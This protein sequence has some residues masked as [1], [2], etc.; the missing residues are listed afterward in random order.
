MAEQTVSERHDRS[1]TVIAASETKG[2]GRWAGIAVFSAVV[3]PIVLAYIVFY[4][5]IGIPSGTINQ[6]S[7]LTPAQSVSELDLKSYDGE[8]VI[9]ADQEPRWRYLV[10]AGPECLQ[11]CEQLLYTTRQVHI[12]LG[13]KAH[14]VERLLVTTIPQADDRIRGLR[15]T[16]PRLRLATVDAGQV[17][18]WLADSNQTNLVQPGVLLVDQ[19]GF[20]MMAYNDRHSGNEL[21]K[22]IKR[23]L[24]YSYEQ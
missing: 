11:P 5:G 16:H 20:A 7:L 3:L 18:R 4:T 6:G 8:Q 21:L 13:D 24:K 23:L 1:S 12:R 17:D 9:L 10:M 14:R 15:E 2:P 19:N 22:D